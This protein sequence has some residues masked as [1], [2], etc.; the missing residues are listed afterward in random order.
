MI[1]GCTVRFFSLFFISVTSNAPPLR[2]YNLPYLD[3][4]ATSH[5]IISV[6]FLPC[7]VTTGHSTPLTQLIRLNFL[8]FSASTLSPHN[9]DMLPPRL[10]PTLPR[11]LM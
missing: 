3:L 10:T 5:A 4:W 7:G 1:R 11:H 2:A 8:S 6:E 9:A